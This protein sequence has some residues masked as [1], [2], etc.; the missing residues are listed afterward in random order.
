VSRLARPAARRRRLGDRGAAAVEMALVLPVLLLVV[1]GIIDFGRVLN[2]QVKVTE[3]ARE[4]ARAASVAGAGDDRVAMANTRVH[5]VDPDISIAGGST[6]CEPPI[7]ENEDATV[8][9][10]Y[11]LDWV[12]PVGDIAGIFGGGGWGASIT[13]TG[14]G[15]MPCR[16]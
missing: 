12:T 9:T 7:G 10:S 2:A 8:H 16:A 5:K 14:T 1:F 4:G 15:V 6:Y 3:A 11:T 13:L